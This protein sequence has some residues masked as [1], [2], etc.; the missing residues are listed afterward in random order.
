MRDTG[1]NIIAPTQDPHLPHITHNSRREYAT[2]SVIENKKTRFES[3]GRLLE[4]TGD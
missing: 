2:A 4:M 1:G 3:A